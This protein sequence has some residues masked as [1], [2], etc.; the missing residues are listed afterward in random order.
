MFLGFVMVIPPTLIFVPYD[1]LTGKRIV[2][3]VIA[4]ATNVIG[5]GV[6]YVAFRRGKVGVIVPIAATEG[7]VAA[8]IAVIAGPALKVSVA[9]LL[10][11]IGFGVVLSAIH[12]DPPSADDSTDAKIRSA[13]LAVPVAL[14]FGINLYCAGKVG[15]SVSVWWVVIAARLFG[16]LFLAAPLA[17]RRQLQAP[18]R[19][20]PL[21]AGAG[22]GEVLGV[23]SYTLG[24]RHELAVAAVIGSL[25]SA[26]SAVAA[27]FFFG[28]RLTR[29]QIAGLVIVVAGTATLSALST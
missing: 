24:A 28:E 4:G 7:V 19:A 2:L 17:A 23:I 3:L 21:V 27:Y 8:L 11:V 5:L 18:G 15:L 22:L 13:V 1:Q 14:L 10:P 29:L 26:L 12:P 6:E 9:V 20:L 25:F 16:S